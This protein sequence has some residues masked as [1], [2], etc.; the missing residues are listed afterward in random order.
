MATN[1]QYIQVRNLTDNAVVYLI[2]EDN[3]RRVF[4]PNE[5][6]LISRE[7][8]KKLYYQPGGPT[9]IQDFL[10]IND[11]ELAIEFGVDPDLYAH[12]YS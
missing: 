7:E 10:R 12:E 4:G 3:L 11:K 9:L 8:L 5:D 6:K 1:E 2:P